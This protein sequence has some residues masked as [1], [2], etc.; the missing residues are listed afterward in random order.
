MS[1]YLD[2][3]KLKVSSKIE[4][5]VLFFKMSFSFIANLMSIINRTPVWTI[6]KEMRK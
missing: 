4:T 5:G 6:D 1:K 3:Q 2:I